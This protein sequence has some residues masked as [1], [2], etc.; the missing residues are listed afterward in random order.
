MKNVFIVKAY[1]ELIRAREEID[2]VCFE[3][4]SAISYYND[5]L[6]LLSRLKQQ[7]QGSNTSV[8]I[9]KL[10]NV[11]V[12]ACVSHITQMEIK[13]KNRA[14][15]CAKAQAE[16]LSMEENYGGFPHINLVKGCVPSASTS[17]TSS[18]P[19]TT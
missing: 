1:D 5:R 8:D 16:V 4:S 3:I 15:A 11:S 18:T 19:A 7:I 9:G 6:A 13:L 12:T 17:T 2:Y 14:D 10:S